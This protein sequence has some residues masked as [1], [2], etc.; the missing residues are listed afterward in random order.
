MCQ[1]DDYVVKYLYDTEAHSLKPLDFSAPME[2]NGLRDILARYGSLAFNIHYESLH[3]FKQ[4]VMSIFTSR[5]ARLLPAFVGSYRKFPFTLS[6]FLMLEPTLLSKAI[7]TTTVVRRKAVDTIRIICTVS[8]LFEDL[9]IE[10]DHIVLSTE[11]DIIK[12]LGQVY[13]EYR[14]SC[15]QSLFVKFERVRYEK[16]NGRILY[17]V[18]EKKSHRP[19]SRRRSSISF[20][21]PEDSLPLAKLRSENSDNEYDVPLAKLVRKLVFAI[22]NEVIANF[23]CAGRHERR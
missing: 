18:G 15:P 9:G 20:S 13:M 23:T 10:L 17:D 3:C 14:A 4:N 16:N 11:G 6:A 2:L 22:M 19:A 8:E 21:D 1:V 7:F 12:V 5:Q